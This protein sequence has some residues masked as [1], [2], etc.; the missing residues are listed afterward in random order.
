MLDALA[1]SLYATLA[2]V[3]AGEREGIF[4]QFLRSG[5]MGKAVFALLALFSLVSWTIMI[6]KFFQLTRSNRHTRAFALIAA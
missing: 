4:E 5:A 3:T 1:P 2:Q 6:G